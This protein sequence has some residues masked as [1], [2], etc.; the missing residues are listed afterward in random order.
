MT[1]KFSSNNSPFIVE[2]MDL[3]IPD[4]VLPSRPAPL[5][6]GT[7][8]WM[9]YFG[10]YPR[11]CAEIIDGNIRELNGSHVLEVPVNSNALRLYPTRSEIAAVQC[12]VR[13]KVEQIYSQIELFGDNGLIEWKRLTGGA[14]IRYQNEVIYLQFKICEETSMFHVIISKPAGGPMDNLA[15][16]IYCL[17]MIF[18]TPGLFVTFDFE[19]TQE[20][21]ERASVVTFETSVAQPKEEEPAWMNDEIADWKP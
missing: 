3:S 20:D 19:L 2:E 14:E 10:Q 1:S 17:R 18:I 15:S 8:A 16:F 6:R 5:R 21:V 12:D 9:N 13:D 7:N 11:A 4:Q